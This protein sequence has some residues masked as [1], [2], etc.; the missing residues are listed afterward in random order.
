[1]N[2]FRNLDK[3]PFSLRFLDMLSILLSNLCNLALFP[4]WVSFLLLPLLHLQCVFA[5]FCTLVLLLVDLLKKENPKIDL[6][7]K[8]LYMVLIYISLTIKH[9]LVVK[10]Q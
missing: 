2:F 3:T 7:M 8:K 6:L 5:L 1:M 9:S 4:K 10:K